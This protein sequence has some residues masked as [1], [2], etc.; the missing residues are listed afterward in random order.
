VPGPS[1]LTIP[2]GMVVGW[3][4]G[5]S[6][7]DQIQN[8][9]YPFTCPPQM[10]KDQIELHL[11]KGVKFTRLPPNLVVESG[12]F[13][14]SANYTAVGQVIRAERTFTVSSKSIVC[15]PELSD[16]FNKVLKSMR[17]DMRSQIFIH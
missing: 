4:K 5:I 15:P 17:K 7:R 2:V 6:S 12:P 9:S 14:Y 13:R 11:P 16:D 3:I 1:A 10:H 8:T